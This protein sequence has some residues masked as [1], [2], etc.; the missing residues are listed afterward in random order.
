MVAGKIWDRERDRPPAFVALTDANGFIRGVGE[1]MPEA[2]ADGA[3][4]GAWVGIRPGI[5]GFARYAVHGVLTS[6]HAVCAGGVVSH[7]S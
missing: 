6:E 4:S 5:Q 7:A 3:N 2:A 1:F